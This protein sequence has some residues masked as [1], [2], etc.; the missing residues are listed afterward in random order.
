MTA[1]IRVPTIYE[2]L[3]ISAQ[4]AQGTPAV[5][6]TADI[7]TYLNCDLNPDIENIIREDK[8]LGRSMFGYVA[9]GK[10][11]A[12]WSVE[13]Y[14]DLA[15]AATPPN[16]PQ[17]EQLL[18]SAMAAAPVSFNDTVQAS[19]SPTASSFAVS[20]AAALKPGD[21]LAVNIGGSFGWQMRPIQ[22]IATNTLT[23]AIPFGAAP[24]ST[25]VVKARIY[26]LGAVN[27]FM[28]IVDWLRDQT[29]AV[30]NLARMAVDCIAD[31]FALDCSQTIVRVSAS[32]P[33]SYVVEQQSPA[34][35]IYNGT[36]PTLPA[37]PTNLT[38]GFSPETPYLNG[39]FFL[40]TTLLTA[41][42]VKMTLSNGA[43][44][45]PVP[46]GSQ[47]A[48]GVILGQRKIALDL[49]VDGNSANYSYLLD[50]EQKNPHSLFFHTG[51]T[52]G[53]F[54]GVYSP[55][56]VLGLNDLVKNDVTVRLNFGSSLQFATAS[57]NEVTISLG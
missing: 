44:Q 8:G 7:L 15:S 2:V 21:S 19:P 35:G 48:D 25:S 40:D 11:T 27:N 50:A 38:T 28:T 41:Y 39:E 56:M 26:R 34:S 30:S 36:F 3:S 10:Q 45:L 1:P 23:F 46:F 22:S 51:Q 13:V 32:G 18:V 9:P 49:E 37:L 14:A 17:F 31:T 29:L 47:F 4:S 52:Q 5:P 20:N 24:A 12:K 53:Q 6:A 16:P 33:A 43:K 54:I 55:K 57:D 42:T